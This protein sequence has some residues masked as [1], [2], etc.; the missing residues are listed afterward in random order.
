MEHP[1]AASSGGVADVEEKAAA[2]TSPAPASHVTIF[3]RS[4]DLAPLPATS[5][6]HAADPTRQ[7]TDSPLAVTDMSE[8]PAL[9]EI[10]LAQPKTTLAPIIAAAAEDKGADGQSVRIDVLVDN[11]GR[12]AQPSK[13]VEA[14]PLLKPHPNLRNP[15]V[16]LSR[17]PS[18]PYPS[19][20]AEPHVVPSTLPWLQ[21]YVDRRWRFL[22][23]AYRR[24]DVWGLR[25]FSVC[26]LIFIAVYSIVNLA[27][28]VSGIAQLATASKY[29]G[30]EGDLYNTGTNFGIYG[31]INVLLLLLPNTR[32]NVWQYVFGMSFERSVWYHKWIARVAVAEL[33]IHGAAIYADS[34]YNNSLWDDASSGGVTGEYGSGSIAFFIAVAIVVLSLYPFRR[35]MHE[36]FL[37]L[38]IV[39]FI[40]F[41]VFAFIHEGTVAL[42]VP[43]LVLYAVDWALRISMWRQP[44]R[45]LNVQLLPG[46]VTRITF[47]KDRFTYQA[48]QYIFICLPAVSPWE[49]HPFSLSSSPHHPVLTVHCKSIGRWTRRLAELARQGAD[50]KRDWSKLKMHTEGPYGQL[51]VPLAHYSSVL[52]VC[53]GIGVTPLGSVYN[54]LVHDHYRGV[55]RLRQLKLVWSL[56]E[57]A[58]I[59]SLYDDVRR[60]ETVDKEERVEAAGEPPSYYFH[61]RALAQRDALAD[62]ANDAPPTG[63]SV[64][65]PIQPLA[66][67][68]K[69]AFHLT[70]LSSTDE[71]QAQLRGVQ[72]YYGEWIKEGR[73]ELAVAFAEMKAAMTEERVTIAVPDGVATAGANV[74]GEQVA[75]GVVQRCAV[76]ACGPRLLIDDVRAFCI[77]QSSA[78]VKFDLHEEEFSW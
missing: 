2:A 78:A 48:G 26:E 52:L 13:A 74:G 53:G 31:A 19:P 32:N 58:L 51:S 63:S 11:S 68:I 59:S 22:F 49:W 29:D 47:Q 40:A 66:G 69:N 54:S 75:G 17:G 57:P 76:L 33:A 45:V 8:G 64:R 21:R 10:E 1:Q 71:Q 50:E 5:T 4:L 35:Y 23:P 14:E 6:V 27:L 28:I 56:R 16:D 41:L 77:R 15:N 25:G 3:R 9:E 72:S 18:V 38:H 43:A 70:K 60:A 73:P 55:R 34:Y 20:N 67:R 36:W 42:V 44:V 12:R 61:P 30:D 24:L 46:G 62:A 37:R 39:L 65:L 7:L